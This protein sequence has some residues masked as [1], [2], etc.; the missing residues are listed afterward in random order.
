MDGKKKMETNQRCW[1]IVRRRHLRPP[2]RRSPPKRNKL[3]QQHRYLLRLRYY[4]HLEF[5]TN[6]YSGFIWFRVFNMHTMPEF[7]EF[8]MSITD[9][10][11]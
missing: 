6:Y 4:H 9:C 8:N 1:L 10:V 7:N 11:S 5:V 3:F 2:F